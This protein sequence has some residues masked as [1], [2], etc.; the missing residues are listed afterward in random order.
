LAKG[1]GI[2]LLGVVVSRVVRYVF[3]KTTGRVRLDAV[4]W[5]YLG[6][7]LRY[8]TIIVF[9]ISALKVMG[10]PVNSLLATFGITGLIIGLGARQSMANYF[11][12][13]MMLA[14]K[15]FK[16]GDLVEFGPPPQI[17]V[18][19]EVKMTCTK[20]DTLDNVRIT[21]PNSVIW[22]NKVTNFSVHDARAIRIPLAVPYDVDVDWVE[23]IAL[24]VLHRHDAV[25]NDPKPAFT[26]SDVTPT[27]V[28]A[29]LTAWSG[30]GK[31]NIFGDV[32]TEMRKDF[33]AAGLAVT[34]PAKEIDL[35]REE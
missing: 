32:I 30:V 8:I 11:A 20:L 19:R 6:T 16:K 29:A 18:V 22:R 9:L 17:G 4:L 3:D 26:V 13:I 33:E 10:F 27:D 34:V 35:K 24:D 1:L 7:V 31:M 25:L 2:L 23:D 21:V 28:R 5:E 15:P 12:G 14:A